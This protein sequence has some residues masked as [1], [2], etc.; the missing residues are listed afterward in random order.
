MRYPVLPID[1]CMAITAEYLD[2]G[3]RP[4]DTDE[5]ALSG[6]GPDLD[7]GP[8]QAVAARIHD[9]LELA[10]PTPGPGQ[11]DRIEG[12]AAAELHR[13]VRNLPTH[14]LDDPQFWRYVGLQ[15]LWRFVVWREHARFASRQPSRYLR[16]VDAKVAHQCVA[17]RMFLRADAVVDGDDYMLAWAL[18]DGAVLWELMLSRG[19][20]ACPVLTRALVVEQRDRPM[21][22]SSQQETV[23]RLQRLT[24]NLVTALLTDDDAA[25]LV[26]EARS[27]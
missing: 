14:V 11:A 7:P 23:R 5:V 18:P 8:L 27:A 4:I 25:E 3:W 22:Q 1:A 16:L 24:A 10:E 2:A 15:H 19:V 26:G 21:T 12:W 6:K 9:R 13:A 20:V 17:T